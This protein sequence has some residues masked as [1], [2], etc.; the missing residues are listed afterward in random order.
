MDQSIAKILEYG[1]LGV[2]VVVFGFVIW[3]LYKGKS[4]DA[5][6]WKEMA[7]KSSQEFIHI[8][9]KQNETNSKIVDVQKQMAEDNRRF[10]DEMY[11]RIEDLPAKVAERIKLDQL[12][13]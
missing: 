8:S 10:H 13:R 3:H 4:E 9:I 7:Q 12:D 2:A 6:T 11:K 1:L 5:K